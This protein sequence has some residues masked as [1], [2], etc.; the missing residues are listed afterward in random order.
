MKRQEILNKIGEVFTLAEE[1]KYSR[2]KANGEV[3][4]METR[5]GTYKTY[6][7]RMKTITKNIIDNVNPI[8][9]RTKEKY[10]NPR[11]WDNQT[12]DMYV[13]IRLK[14]VN[15]GDLTV[16]SL[17]NE[18]QALD[19]FR[20]FCNKKDI[21]TF[22]KNSKIKIGG[23]ERLQ[24]RLREIKEEGGSTSYKDSRNAK[25]NV[26]EARSI[27][28]H[29][30]GPQS[31][32]VKNILENI[33]ITGGRLSTVLLSEAQH[34]L[35]ENNSFHLKFQKGGAVRNVPISTDG[36][37]VLK[38]HHKSK[39]GGR[40]PYVFRKKDGGLM[41][42]KSSMRTVE[43]YVEK[44]VERAQKAGDLPTLPSGKDF[45]VHSFRKAYAQNHY[46]STENMNRD[47][48]KKA[49]QHYLSLQNPKN[50]KQIE[51]R[52]EREKKRINNNRKD[53]R[54]F[55]IEEYRALYTSLCLS[56]SRIDVVRHYINRTIKEHNPN[57]R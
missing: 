28:K 3:T 25:M 50:R 30:K 26:P 40:Q 8:L 1:K 48:I 49:I 17:K 43:R 14:K 51:E 11:F 47:Q 20:Q 4:K 6:S 13:N 36:A 41:G 27:I 34:V 37:I 10:N 29:I 16:K 9:R 35:T 18:L 56:H 24:E 21:S 23:H 33:L 52:M 5:H 7:N 38:E 32:Q 55:T 54:D 2:I 44:A 22:T 57:Q 42:L 45:T 12:V 15:S 53:S 46:N 39:K 19:A 31:E